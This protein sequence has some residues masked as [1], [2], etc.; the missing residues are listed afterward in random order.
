[1]VNSLHLS[2]IPGSS[3]SGNLPVSEEGRALAASLLSQLSDS[4]I[5]DVF[6]AARSSLMRGDSISDWVAGFKEKLQL[7]L[8]DVVCE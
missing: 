1:M 6:S 8:L 5:N 3:W 4:Q 2:G 7:Q